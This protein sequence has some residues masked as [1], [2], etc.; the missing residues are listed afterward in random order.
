MKILIHNQEL[1]KKF[2]EEY[3]CIHPVESRG[4]SNRH[5]TL[6]YVRENKSKFEKSKEKGTSEFAHDLKSKWLGH[7]MYVH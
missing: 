4:G 2:F 1:D 6:M 5:C 3:G 7:L